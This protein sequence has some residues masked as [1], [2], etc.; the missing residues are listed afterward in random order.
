M[1]SIFK[2]KTFK[3]ALLQFTVSVTAIFIAQNPDIKGIAMIG[4]IKSLA[5][6][7]LRSITNEEVTF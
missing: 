5:D 2:S 1:K 6:M 3:L 4:M 7:Y